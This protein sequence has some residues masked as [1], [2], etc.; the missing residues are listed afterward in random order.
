MLSGPRVYG[1]VVMPRRRGDALRFQVG[2]SSISMKLPIL[3]RAFGATDLLKVS[4]L[5]VGEPFPHGLVLH[6]ALYDRP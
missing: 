5:L 2:N 3:E 6:P 1:K 4:R